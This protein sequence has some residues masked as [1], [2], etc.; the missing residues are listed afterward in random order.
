MFA[1]FLKNLPFPA[2]LL[3]GFL[4][5][6]RLAQATPDPHIEPDAYCLLILR[7]YE[8]ILQELAK[9][10]KNTPESTPTADYRRD[11]DT[12]YQRRPSCF[13]YSVGR[14]LLQ[15]RGLL[16]P[17]DA[18]PSLRPAPTPP[19][20][21]RIPR[22]RMPHKF[23]LFWSV[24]TGP[25]SGG[26][27]PSNQ[28]GGSG[29]MPVSISTWSLGGRIGFI[30]SG[31]FL[32]GDFSFGF[33]DA[34]YNQAPFYEFGQLDMWL[35]RGGITGGG[36]FG[37]FMLS[38]GVSVLYMQMHDGGFFSEAL[39]VPVELGVGM[40]IPVGDFALDLRV[41]L[42]MAFEGSEKKGTYSAARFVVSFGS[43]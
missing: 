12:L 39:Y 13:V 31:F 9:R 42:E 38:A 30:K 40:R 36:F 20:I 27:E 5:F 21:E 24:E 19:A 6:P 4:C 16:L 3:C 1:V 43:R 26:Y 23:R 11:L 32:T 25:Y 22:Y 33:G 37:S 7:H 41:V 28:N 8:N 35:V 17:Q 18:I 10:L 29:G 14:S 2:L 34:H 15:I